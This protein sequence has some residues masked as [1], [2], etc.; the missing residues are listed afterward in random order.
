MN[1]LISAMKE[2]F[3][4]AAN[5]GGAVARTASF[6]LENVDWTGT[7]NTAAPATNPIVDAQLGPACAYSG[8][9]GSASLVA[10]QALAAVS[11]QLMWRPSYRNRQGEPDMA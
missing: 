7:L 2:L 11:D 4:A 10:A 1:R 8:P 6:T 9:Q 3:T 5:S